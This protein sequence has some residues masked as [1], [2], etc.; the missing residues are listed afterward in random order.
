MRAGQLRSLITIEQ[1][2]EGLPD[3]HNFRA[4]NWAPVAQPWADITGLAGSQAERGIVVD[5]T[6][7]HRIEIRYRAGLTPL[8]RV[9]HEGT[10]YKITAIIDPDKRKRR[11]YLFCTAVA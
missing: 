9:S 10:V 11:L 8:M 3:A 2:T 7:T 5:A 4:P 6:T 1:P